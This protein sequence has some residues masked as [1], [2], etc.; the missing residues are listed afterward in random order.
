MLRSL[1]DFF[2][3]NNNVYM[4]TSK[5]HS[6]TR[7]KN[8]LPSQIQTPVL[9]IVIIECDDK[10]M[11][12]LLNA[13]CTDT[14]KET[15][16]ISVM[17]GKISY[18]L[19][20][21]TMMVLSDSQRKIK[22]HL[23]DDFIFKLATRSTRDKNILPE[24]YTNLA[25]AAQVQFILPISFSPLFQTALLIDAHT[26]FPFATF[27]LTDPI[28]IHSKSASE[29]LAIRDAV[30]LCYA[31]ISDRKVYYSNINKNKFNIQI[32]NAYE[33]ISSYHVLIKIQT[34]SSSWTHTQHLT[35]SGHMLILN[36]KF[37]H[38]DVCVI[39]LAFACS[40]DLHQSKFQPNI[41]NG[42]LNIS[43]AKDTA[44]LLSLTTFI[45]EPITVL[46]DSTTAKRWPPPRLATGRLLDIGINFPAPSVVGDY[47][48]ETMI[49][50]DAL[51]AMFTHAE[52][53][54]LQRQPG[55]HLFR[56]A[57]FDLRE[58]LK[59][60]YLQA[61]CG[62]QRIV[63]YTT[64]TG[65]PHSITDIRTYGDILFL[66]EGIY[67]YCGRPTLAVSYL[68]MME[69]ADAD[70]NYLT[71]YIKNLIRTELN[72]YAS[73]IAQTRSVP[74]SLPSDFNMYEY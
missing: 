31:D 14:F 21:G 61:F 54:L 39:R 57:D 22:F 38:S 23:I 35:L 33:T 30:S 72:T 64:K 46:F 44:E 65:K 56:N 20:T 42:T 19:T 11:R 2:T 36:I 40:L 27:Q 60:M 29:A 15:T 1:R 66:Y 9:Q 71:Q 68:D 70:V 69:I 18:D 58:S 7:I 8:F 47:D 13:M 24:Y 12:M 67:N 41:G 59:Q 34:Q 17:R 50:Y 5:H 55:D 52:F 4:Y 16:K 74:H 45:R 25:H 37:S 32:V 73:T 48:S 63:L 3:T 6:S 53:Q 28:T 10:T 43:L 62:R 49:V 51:S 26:W